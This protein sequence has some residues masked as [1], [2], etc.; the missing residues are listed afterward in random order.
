MA[1]IALSKACSQYGASMGRRAHHCGEHKDTDNKFSVA[2]VGLD[3]GGY[4]SGGAYWG[5]PNNLYRVYAEVPDDYI[6][7]FIRADNR[8]AAK[9]KVRQ[10]YPNARFY[11]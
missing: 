9:A 6:E 10:D 4:D 2:L 5:T 11:R 1:R 3:T 8:E 7:F